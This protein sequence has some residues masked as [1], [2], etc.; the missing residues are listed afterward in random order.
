MD[1]LVNQRRYGHGTMF[2]RL[3]YALLNA[4]VQPP[5]LGIMLIVT[6]VHAWVWQA[7]QSKLCLRQVKSYNA[8]ILVRKKHGSEP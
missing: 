3:S 6:V 8:G 7:A 1:P 4:F 5:P 2:N